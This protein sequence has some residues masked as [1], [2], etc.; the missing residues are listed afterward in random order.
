[1]VSAKVTSSL[2]VATKDGMAFHIVYWDKSGKIVGGS[3]G[4]TPGAFRPGST[5]SVALQ[6]SMNPPP[7]DR[8]ATAKIFFDVHA[9]DLA[10]S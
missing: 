10:A 1:M 5:R 8:Y 4:Y 3:S 2:D 9:M 7:A 6:N